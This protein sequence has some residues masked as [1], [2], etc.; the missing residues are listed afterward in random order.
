MSLGGRL[1]NVFVA[2]GEVFD[3]VKNRPHDPANWLVPALAS[4]I[5]GIVFTF[6][7]FSQAQIIQGM[8]EMQEKQ[9]QQMVDKGKLTR[10]QADQ[11]MAMSEKFTGPT[12][13]KVFGIVG[14]I[15]GVTMKLT[16]IALLIWAIGNLVF[17]TQFGYGKAMEI[18][19]LSAGISVVDAVIRMLL[20][21]IY[22]N[23]SMSLGPVLLVGHFDPQNKVHML[24][25]WLDV[26]LFWQLG[27][28]S[29][30]LARLSGRSFTKS[31]IWL[32]GSLFLI[33]ACFVGAMMLLSKMLAGLG[34]K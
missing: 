1:M 17:K 18:V 9:M 14:S 26:F 22:S 33:T 13:M 28:W 5:V 6:V 21:V 8:R 15:I 24:L 12:A 31:L 2:P 27:V 19:G 10:Q 4:I 16:L 32:A 29:L 30:G 20:A 34:G 23:P 11:A 3:D 7:V 25:A